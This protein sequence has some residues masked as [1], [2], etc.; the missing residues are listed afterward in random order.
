M[1]KPGCRDV[2]DSIS[3]HKT[4]KGTADHIQAKYVSPLNWLMGAETAKCGNCVAADH[5]KLS[6]SAKGNSSQGIVLSFGI[7]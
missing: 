4:T 7:K 2:S 5:G 3:I 6:N 1:W